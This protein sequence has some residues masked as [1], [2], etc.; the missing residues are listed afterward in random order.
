MLLFLNQDLTGR[1]HEIPISWSLADLENVLDKG[2]GALNL[3]FSP[4]FKERAIDLCYGNV[5]I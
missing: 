5:G 1:V 4:R 2:G 3:Q